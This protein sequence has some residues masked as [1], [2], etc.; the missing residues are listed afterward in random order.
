MFFCPEAKEAAEPIIKKQ[1][2]FS[3]CE[4]YVKQIWRLS[5]IREVY[6]RVQLK[7]DF[8]LKVITEVEAREM[9]IKKA[10]GRKCKLGCSSV[11]EG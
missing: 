7:P 5:L 3:L 11:R 6:L 9:K 2:L 8:L 10:K 1:T 4:A